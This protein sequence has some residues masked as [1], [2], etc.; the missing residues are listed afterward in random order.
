M[1]T[2]Q[3]KVYL[4]YPHSGEPVE[5]LDRQVYPFNHH[6]NRTCAVENQKHLAI[7][8][9]TGKYVV[10]EV[11]IED[12]IVLVHAEQIKQKNSEPEKPKWNFQKKKGE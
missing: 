2:D 12:S 1:R 3:F 6:N 4:K 10:G 7:L 11:E 5:T 8:L 9:A